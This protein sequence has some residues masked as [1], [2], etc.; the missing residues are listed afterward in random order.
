MRKREIGLIFS[1]QG[2]N[3]TFWLETFTGELDVN[4]RII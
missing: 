3:K 2:I 1:M 4:S